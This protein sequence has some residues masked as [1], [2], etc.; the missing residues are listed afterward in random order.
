MFFISI[1][2]KFLPTISY[3]Y[4]DTFLVIVRNTRYKP[5]KEPDSIQVSYKNGYMFL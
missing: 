3:I 5:T 4:L 2:D 1:S